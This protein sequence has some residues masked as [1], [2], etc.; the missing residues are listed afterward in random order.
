MEGLVLEGDAVL[1]V[2]QYS[3]T[4]DFS[5]DLEL[6]MKIEQG[7]KTRLNFISQKLFNK[8]LSLLSL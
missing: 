1:E 5:H 3:C 6:A 7:R 4:C 8:I 2:W